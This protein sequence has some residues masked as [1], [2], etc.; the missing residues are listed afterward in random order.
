MDLQE[1]LA[2]GE[3]RVWVWL[4][5][6]IAARHP[7]KVLK[8]PETSLV[9]MRAR[10]SVEDSEFYLGE[11][12]ITEAV[13]EINGVLGYGIALED[14]PERALCHAVIK[15]ALA[16]DLPEREEIQEVVDQQRRQAESA[17]DRKEGMVAGTRVR[18]AIMEG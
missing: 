8:P 1:I 13:V 3:K 9:M 14:E 12:L 4:T 16:A 5:E 18:F 17:S 10:D 7:V 2:E 11:V 15:A 6:K